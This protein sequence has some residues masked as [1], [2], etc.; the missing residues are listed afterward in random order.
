MARSQAAL[1]QLMQIN[2]QE[3]T[4]E[5]GELKAKLQYY[6]SL[7]KCLESLRQVGTPPTSGSMSAAGHS[8]GVNGSGS[9]KALESAALVLFK[10]KCASCHDA[11][12]AAANGKGHVW[13][14]GGSFAKLTEMDRRKIMTKTYKGEMP[15]PNNKFNIAPLTDHEVG[16]IMGWLSD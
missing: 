5:L 2:P 4:A 14:E 10:T 13:L 11:S 15:P 16:T 8:I 9:P 12:Q 3:L 6:E 1:N 7:A